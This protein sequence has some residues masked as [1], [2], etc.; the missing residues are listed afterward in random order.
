ML[1]GLSRQKGP[2]HK[3]RIAMGRASIIIEIIPFACFGKGN[4]RELQNCTIQV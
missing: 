4:C 3:K 2:P 1:H